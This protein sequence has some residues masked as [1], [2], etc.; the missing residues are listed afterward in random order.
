M[1][2]RVPI[3]A[4]APH[5]WDDGPWMNRQNFLSRLAKRGWPTVYSHGALNL[6]NRYDQVWKQASVLGRFDKL[7]GVFV[8]RP[9]KLLPRWPSFLLWDKFALKLYNHKLRRVIGAN[10]HKDFI[11]F[12]FNP[13]FWPY[14]EVLQPR[15][16]VFHIYDVYSQMGE[17]TTE[18]QKYLTMLASRAD[19]ITAATHA[20][21]RSL[22][23]E[24]QNK[25]HI[26]PNGVDLNLFQTTDLPA[27]P[28]DLSVIPS[29][30]IANIGTTNRK[31]DLKLIAKIASRR[32]EWNWVFVGSVSKEELLADDEAKEGYLACQACPN[33]YFLGE[34]NRLNIPA[35]A[36]HMDV[37]TI[38][39]RIK[40]GEWVSAGYPVK[41]NEYLAVGKPVVAAQQEVIVD[42]FSDVV[43]I[44]NGADE[45]EAAIEKALRTGGIATPDK[46]RTVAAEN[47]WDKRVDLLEGW[48]LKVIS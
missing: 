36:A 20:M 33:I 11:A 28:K 44:A 27:C 21:S 12:V 1:K 13:V 30:R 38:C 3:I 15:W 47:T 34:K 41:L 39:Y 42:F 24:F 5:P 37:N 19:L 4:F 31:I 16:V 29:P 6:W 23:N 17:W 43:A 32:P 2:K 48:L 45:W 7:D 25:A 35:Y 14:I 26:L 40:E 9:G 46:R 18:Q 22:P 8:D 10:S